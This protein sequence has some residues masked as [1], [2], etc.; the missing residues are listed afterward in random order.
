[1]EIRP[2]LYKNP[3]KIFES[4]LGLFIYKVILKIVQEASY[5]ITYLVSLEKIPNGEIWTNLV[6]L[7]MSQLFSGSRFGG[8]KVHVE[9]DAAVLSRKHRRC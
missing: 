4:C 1:M 7:Q 2:K 5:F 8:K 9:N 3:P 6:T